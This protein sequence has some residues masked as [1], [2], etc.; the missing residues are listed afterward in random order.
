M[1]DV[2]VSTD[3]LDDVKLAQIEDIVVR[4]TGILPENIII[5]SMTE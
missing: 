4:K 1:A 3:V 5:S 2:V